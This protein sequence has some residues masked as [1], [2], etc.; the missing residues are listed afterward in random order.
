MKDT[1]VSANKKLYKNKYEFNKIL[2]SD[3]YHILRDT[4][5][6]PGYQ[7]K[8]FNAFM[9][10]RYYEHRIML[11]RAYA[12]ALLACVIGSIYYLVA[13]IMLIMKG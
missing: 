6:Y 11:N 1:T 5:T 10:C 13:I 9:S 3:S 8:R 4:E 12:L 7:L 2:A